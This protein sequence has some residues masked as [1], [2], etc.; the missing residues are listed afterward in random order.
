LFSHHLRREPDVLRGQPA[1]EVLGEGLFG[2]DSPFRRA[3]LAG[4]RREG[5]RASLCRANGDSQP[6]SVTGAPLMDGL[7]CGGEPGAHGGRYL[8]MVRPEIHT[9]RD[10]GSDAL[11]FDGMAAR[12]EAM[13]QVFQLIDHLRD[14][15]ASVLITGE[16]GTGKELV[17]RAIHDEDL[18]AEIL[19]A[20]E[21]HPAEPGTTV[22]DPFP[23]RDDIVEALRRSRNRRGAAAELLGISRTTLWRR[24]KKLRLG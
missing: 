23:N 8:L 3:L 16:S 4:Q 17:A 24:L 7:Q 2:P 9:G 15:D 10:S 18:P 5:W 22:M 21:T 19:S 6:V 14:S 13:R 1:A 12:S 11:H 20:P